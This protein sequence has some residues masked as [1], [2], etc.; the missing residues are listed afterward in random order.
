M[1]A[2]VRERAQARH[3][4][5]QRRQCLHKRMSMPQARTHAHTAHQR[6]LRVGRGR[7]RRRSVRVE[8]GGG[9]VVNLVERH[10]AHRARSRLRLGRC[11]WLVRQYAHVAAATERVA[12]RLHCLQ[13]HAGAH[14]RRRTGHNTDR[15][16]TQTHHK[17][18]TTYRGDRERCAARWCAATPGGCGDF[19]L[20]TP[21]TVK[22]RAR[23]CVI[24][25]RRSRS[26]LLMRARRS[27]RTQ[28]VTTRT[29]FSS[30]Q[31]YRGER[32]CRGE[33]E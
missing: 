22:H 13:V 2:Y 21:N 32:E 30:M 3:G 24:A 10:R 26:S 28:Y 7:R 25:P 9:R 6:R 4:P 27:V 15:Q 8:G 18:A 31:T 19:A 11:H 20:H 23:T 33:R 1:M 16:H 14:G 5:T 29:N 12:R 17:C